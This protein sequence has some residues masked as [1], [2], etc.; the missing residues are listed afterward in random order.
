MS[1]INALER[2]ISAA[3]NR[4]REGVDRLAAAPTMPPVAT[5]PVSAGDGDLASQ[6]T[7]ERTVN[8]QLEERV[9]A[10]KERQDGKLSGLEAEVDA[11]KV[12]LADFDRDIQRLQQAN[13]D[14]RAVAAEMREALLASTAEAELIN[15]AVLAELEAVKAAHAVGTAEAAAIIAQLTPMLEG[16]Q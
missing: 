12:Q 15:R 8:A 10:L 16:A 4:A 5:T 6:L 9:R 1:D 11:Q 3:L 14:L 13:A 7:E 2:R